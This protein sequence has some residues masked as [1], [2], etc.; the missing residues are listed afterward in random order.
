MQHVW[1][2]L[3]TQE[4]SS[5]VVERVGECCHVYGLICGHSQAAGPD[6]VRGSGPIQSGA[7]EARCCTLVFLT[8]SHRPLRHPSPSTFYAPT[9]LQPRA[10]T[11]SRPELGRSRL[12]PSKPRQS[13]PSCWPAPPAPASVVCG[14]ACA[15]ATTPRGPPL[16]AAQRK[17]PLAPRISKRRSVRS[18]IFEVA[19]SFC[20]PPVECCKGVS[21]TQAAKSRPR[22]KVSAGAQGPPGRWQ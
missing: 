11:R 1:T 10:L 19:S 18:P 15:Q 21:P 22:L 3:V 20:L 2:P 14:P 13:A 17:T 5:G 9:A 4:E 8:P 7:L 6:E 16:R 12:W